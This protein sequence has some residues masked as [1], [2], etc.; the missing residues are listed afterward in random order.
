MGEYIVYQTRNTINGKIYVGVHKISDKSGLDDGYLGSGVALRAAIRK[1]G[2]TSF[3]RTTIST[4]ATELAAF[5]D[6]ARIV[7]R[8]FVQRRDTY[9]QTEG[10]LGGD[11]ITDHPR[12][13]EYI[14]KIRKTC[15]EKEI[16]KN[17]GDSSGEN[18]GFF[19]KS[20][21]DDTKRHLR[22]VNSSENN[23]RSNS[24]VFDGVEYPSI[25]AAE[26]ATGYNHHKLKK[27]G[28]IKT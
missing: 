3:E 10:G 4:H 27:L 22:R 6:E 25:R 15:K 17:F 1:Y 24:C 9:N 21:T 18:N 11:R 7:D 20:H 12:R 19:G 26:R 23:S 13:N 28:L 8:R 5:A 14:A 2:K 16:H